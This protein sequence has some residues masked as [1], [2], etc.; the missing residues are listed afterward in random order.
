LHQFGDGLA[1]G[2]PY[3]F[4]VP[5]AESPSRRALYG[6]ASD[7][8][9]MDNDRGARTHGRVARMAALRA[10]L[11]GREPIG[12]VVTSP[13]DLELLPCTI[14]QPDVFVIPSDTRIAG[15]TMQWTDVRRLLL[16][17]EVLSPSSVRIDRVEKRDFLPKKGRP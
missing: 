17:V 13:A 7:P 11:R 1:V 14:A 15:D 5:L 4:D 16:T 2:P 12:V 8:P 10:P 6:H 9:P 3:R